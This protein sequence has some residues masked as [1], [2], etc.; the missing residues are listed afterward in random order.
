METKNHIEEAESYLR[1][2]LD[3][4]YNLYDLKLLLRKQGYSE[5]ALNKAAAKIKKEFEKQD[6]EREKIQEQEQS[7]VIIEKTEPEPEKE[8]NKSR[9]IFFIEKIKS[10]FKK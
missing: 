2:N 3:K 8:K 6:K 5:V 4:G 9:F 7:K 1:R 10:F